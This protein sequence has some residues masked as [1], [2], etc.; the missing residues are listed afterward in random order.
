MSQETKRQLL[1][2]G[3]TFVGSFLGAIAL[4]IEQGALSPD[5]LS[6][7]VV[8]AVVI[9]AFRQASKVATERYLGLKF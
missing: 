7:P 3:I 6:V 5:A 2:A 8:L 1:S 9:T 4:M